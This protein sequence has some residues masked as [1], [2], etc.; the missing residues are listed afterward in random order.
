[1]LSVTCDICDKE[2]EEVEE[3]IDHR[4]FQ[5]FDTLHFNFG[6]MTL[7]DT[8]ISAVSTLKLKEK[9]GRMLEDTQKQLVKDF[10]VAVR[11]CVDE[12]IC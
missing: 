1:M 5:L 4:N 11:R 10:K 12:G 8:C 9:C 7:C 3:C 2:L 6:C